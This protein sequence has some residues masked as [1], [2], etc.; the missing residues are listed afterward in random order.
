MAD[1]KKYYYLKLKENFF[2]SDELIL[3]E[4]QK[5]GYLY[6]NI[7]LKLYLRSLKNEGKLMFNDRIPY[8]AEILSTIVRHNVAVVEKALFLFEELGLIEKLD[9]GA[10]FMMD[11]Q[12]F[13]GQ[14][15]TEADRIRGY[16]KKIE[17]EKQKLLECTNDVQMYDKNTPEIEL[18]IEKDKE[19][20]IKKEEPSTPTP[21]KPIKKKSSK[22]KHGEY[23]N[24]LLTDEELEKLKNEYP[25]YE[26]AIEYLDEY[27]EMTGKKYKSHYLAMKKWVFSALEERQRKSL[28]NQ[29]KFTRTAPVPKWMN[30]D[31][32]PEKSKEDSCTDEERYELMY[33][34]QMMFGQKED[35]E[36][37][38]KKYFEL[39]GKSIDDVVGHIEECD[40]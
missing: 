11:I 13:I 30:E 5:D 10:I 17:T 6:S 15:S 27:V 23:Q 36:E 39:T 24:I 12:N 35:A 37:T 31:A 3:L 20:E 16:R 29:R 26:E 40:G 22:H 2:D 33:K 28:S 18:E 19:L 34:A 25:N 32:E 4:S 9:N 8:N 7:L 1:N 14:S 38:K 21:S